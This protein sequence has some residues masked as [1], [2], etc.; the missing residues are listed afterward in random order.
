[1]CVEFSLS[2]D[3]LAS[4]F[5]RVCGGW[6]TVVTGKR[7]QEREAGFLSALSVAQGGLCPSARGRSYVEQPSPPSGFDTCSSPNPFSFTAAV[8]NSSRI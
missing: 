5:S 7:G 8:V 1:M 4:G 6:G 2:E 3:L